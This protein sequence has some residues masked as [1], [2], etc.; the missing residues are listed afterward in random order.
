MN[1]SLA[2][3]RTLLPMLR[4]C[5]GLSLCSY[6]FNNILADELVRKYEWE[7]P[8]DS[9]HQKQVITQTDLSVVHPVNLKVKFRKRY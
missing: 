1:L 8:K 5:D 4:K 3:Q 2:E 9:P 7:L 6:V